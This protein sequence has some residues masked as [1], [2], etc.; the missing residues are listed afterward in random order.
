VTNSNALESSCDQVGAV[1]L[2][3]VELTWLQMSVLGVI[4]GITELLPI[5]STAHLR[6]IPG[7]LG[8][9]DPGSA[10]S[11]A[12]QLASFAA[13][14][15]YFSK[16]IRNLGSAS[17]RAVTSRD[18]SSHDF[19]LVLGILLG[20]IP[21][22]VAGLI[23]KPLLNGCHSPLRGLLVVGC[24]SILMSLLL[25][26]AEKFARHRRQFGEITLRDGLIVGV[27][28]AF[29]LIPGV[30]RSG[31]TLTAGLFCGMER[32]TAARFSFLL[33]LPAVTLAGLLE[34]RVLFKAGLSSDGWM[35]LVIGLAVASVTAFIAIYGLLHYL[36]RRSTWI[37]VWYRLLFGA[38]IV[39][40]VLTGHLAN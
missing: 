30:S 13:V 32:E 12:M 24:A 28:Q 15:A 1:D 11:A 34:L 4:Q 9:R 14:I 33:G 20:T 5:S 3:F 22:G 6:V 35:T 26:V 36:E 10:F 27:A 18:F 40:A 31:A 2:G 8:W 25:G 39:V 23:L 38:G 37:F 7:I 29:S 17:V 19:R 21:V 16:D